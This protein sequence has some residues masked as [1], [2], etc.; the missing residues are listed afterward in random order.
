VFG[1]STWPGQEQRQLAQPLIGALQHTAIIGGTGSGKSTL[2]SSL[3]EQDI[4]AGRG[5]LV[6]DVKGDLVSDLLARIPE[7]R[8]RDV[9]VLDPAT[10]G[11]Q[12]GLRLFP[13]SQDV[14]LTADLVIGT[15]REL[16][17]DSFG[18]R[19][20]QYLRM[21]LTALG[22]TPGSTLVDLPFLF[23]DPAFRHRVLRRVRDPL[24][25]ASWQRFEGLSVA[26]QVVQVASPLGKLDELTSRSKLRAVLG[27]SQPKLAF[28]EV[29]AR[30]RIVL[31]RLP[32]GLLGQ[33]AT[34]LLSALVLWQFFAA[35]EARAA[36]APEK[37][38]V[39]T[40]YIDEVSALR[41]VGLPLGD[42][43]ERARGLGVG[44]LLAPQA[45]SRL[46]PE[47]RQIL[48]ANVGTLAAFRLSA[49]EATLVAAE[50]PGVTAE[51]LCHL[52][53]FEIALRLAL[54]PGALTSTMTATT[55]APSGSSRD[56]VAVQTFAASNWGQSIDS[57]DRALA[58]RL[59]FDADSVSDSA[60]D[61]RVNGAEPATV[62]TRRRPS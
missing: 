38:S 21:G 14:E 37:R 33:P 24:L 35:V 40:A 57:V 51:Q 18:V 45:L 31:V 23:T 17:P 30:G 6:L 10:G 12:P 34:R 44:L 61:D 22:S 19:S 54:G 47:L 46:S 8:L 58:E 50:L 60:G 5:C 52:D 62:G 9:I 27:Q 7:R 32:P 13:V 42:L 28:A 36:L 48:L 15:L 49:S 39:F 43:L 1:V 16:W 11:A 41:H 25:I 2:I 53:R 29:L 56:P 3:V 55:P 59:N 20:A 26:D 4:A